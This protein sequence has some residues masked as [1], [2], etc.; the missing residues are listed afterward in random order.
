MNGSLA[1]AGARL[2]DIVGSQLDI[3]DRSHHIKDTRDHI[4]G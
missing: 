3:L 4:V 2:R 1:R